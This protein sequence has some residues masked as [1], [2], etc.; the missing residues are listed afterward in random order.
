V[1]TLVVAENTA[2]EVPVLPVPG[3]VMGIQYRG[4]ILAEQ[5][6]LS[7]AGVTGIQSHLRRFIHPEATGSI[8]VRFTAQGAACLGVPASHLLDRSVSFEDLLGRARSAELCERLCEAPNERARV[9]V[10]EQFLA[11]LPFAND[12]LVAQA[13]G[14]LTQEA[15][16]SV[17][18]AAAKLGVSER[19]LER[20]FRARVGVSPKQFARLARFERAMIA[21]KTP[22]SATTTAGV[23]D[24]PARAASLTSI[25]QRAG[26]YDQSHLARD[27]RQFAGATPGHLF[28]RPR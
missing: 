17:A 19:Q 10:V 5:G 25:A 1:A 27:V 20:R 11:N 18:Q 26:Y 16:L 22:L 6:P 3:A 14:L 8:L 23:D 28:Q 9:L 13:T 7:Q 15:P 2:G 4:Q 24:E 12:S 21:A